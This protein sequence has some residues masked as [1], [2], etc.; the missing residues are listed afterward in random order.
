MSQP[1]H[2]ICLETLKLVR[3]RRKPVPGHGYEVHWWYQYPGEEPKEFYLDP[4]DHFWYY[5]SPERVGAGNTGCDTL[6]GA[7]GDVV[8]S[9][10]KV[11]CERRAR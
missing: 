3:I 6:R 7:K 11:W 8:Y 1:T 10:G 5:D 4:A 9:G 2:G